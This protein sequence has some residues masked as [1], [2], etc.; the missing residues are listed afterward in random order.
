MSKP[1]WTTA[2]FSQDYCEFILDVYNLLVSKQKQYTV[3]SREY[4]GIQNV[5]DEMSF[6]ASCAEEDME[7]YKCE[8]D[9]EFKIDPYCNAYIVCNGVKV[10]DLNVKICSICGNHQGE[11]HKEDC[12]FY[13]KAP[14]AI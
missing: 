11:P 2:E 1:I 5:I 9:N 8:S 3:D 10:A 12:M 4:R 6:D 14:D 7:H 13:T